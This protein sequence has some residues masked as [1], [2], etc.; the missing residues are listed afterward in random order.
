MLQKFFCRQILRNL[1]DAETSNATLRNDLEYATAL[2]NAAKE[3]EAAH[4]DTIS[5]LGAQLANVGSELH[6]LRQ[7]EAELEGQLGLAEIIKDKLS[8][9]KAVEY[10]SI[11]FNSV[12]KSGSSYCYKTLKHALGLSENSLS[13]GYFPRD[14]LVWKRL[15]AFS[16]GNQI[17]HHHTDASPAN[18]WLLAHTEAR[19]LCHTRDLR[20]VMVSWTHHHR[21]S[22]ER[23]TP[24]YTV[25]AFPEAWFDLPLEKQF[26]W[27]IDNRLAFFVT[28]LEEWIAASESG[29][30]NV[31]FTKYE[32]FIRDRAGYFDKIV[33]FCGLGNGAFV[34]P[35]FS[36]DADP[37][38]QFRRGD[39]E[40]FRS[41]L[42]S[43]QLRRANALIPEDLMLR[44]GWVE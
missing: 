26:D 10:P 27:M 4:G 24:H 34:D 28:W 22:N 35:E 8:T 14:M 38:F 12:P 25:A 16:A 3:T 41:V 11:F 36:R 23:S 21:R 15:V 40:E 1:A 32:D 13:V 43:A 31:L 39:P 30:L 6:A 20:Q 37:V 42:S 19:I 9:G 29:E 17:A 18:C 7:R 5:A 33:S 2:L 44:F